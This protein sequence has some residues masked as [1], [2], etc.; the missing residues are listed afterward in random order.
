MFSAEYNVSRCVLL[1]WNLLANGVKVAISR[2]W[3]S[4]GNLCDFTDYHKA[5]E[6][7]TSAPTPAVFTS[8]S[9]NLPEG[10]GG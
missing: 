4:G 8:I 2:R 9:A 3:M 5:Q 7:D 10:M 1:V 6:P